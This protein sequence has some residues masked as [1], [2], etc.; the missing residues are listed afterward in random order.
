MPEDKS[1]KKP[2]NPHR[3]NLQE[4]YDAL[5]GEVI[6]RKQKELLVPQTTLPAT[7]TAHAATM[8]REEYLDCPMDDRSIASVHVAAAPD[9]RLFQSNVWNKTGS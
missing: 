4:S 6:D 1:R 5:V 8:A 2:G 9:S 3:S 7:S